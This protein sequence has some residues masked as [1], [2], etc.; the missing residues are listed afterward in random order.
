MFLGFE[1]VTILPDTLSAST[2]YIVRPD[3]ASSYVELYFTN[4]NGSSLYRIPNV[5]DIQNLIAQAI[6]NIPVGGSQ[7]IIFATDIADRDSRVF[8]SN[9]LVLVQDATA[10]S[11]I[12]SGAALYFYNLTNTTWYVIAEY[13]SLSVTFDWNNIL[14]KPTSTT[15][16]IDAAVAMAHS[17]ANQGFLDKISEAEDGSLIYDGNPI[18]GNTLKEVQW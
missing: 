1:R 4:E 2:V 17:H 16:Q 7:E 14:N 6:S 15:A 18:G 13:D 8:T 10:D 3:A 12:T 11:N 9:A 5:N